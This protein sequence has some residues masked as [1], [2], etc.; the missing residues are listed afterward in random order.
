MKGSSTPRLPNWARDWIIWAR[1]IVG[2]WLA[3]KAMKKVPNPTPRTIARTDHPRLNP[4][5]G[6]VNPTT[7]VVRTKLPA[8]QKGPWCQTSPWR[9]DRGTTSIDLDSMTESVV[10]EDSCDDIVVSW[11][12]RFSA[13]WVFAVIRFGWSPRVVARS[14]VEVGAPISEDIAEVGQSLV[15]ALAQFDVGRDGLL[16][17]PVE[18][19][20]SDR[21]SVRIDDPG[22]RR[23]ISAPFDTRAIPGGE[24]HAG[25]R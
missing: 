25:Q 20:Q 19:G 12:Q 22:C 2:P 6:P 4:I 24:G 16:R 15:P 1:P 17:A 21:P 14:G 13:Q 18:I 11:F 9:S 5:V 23:P 3:W 7:R 10:F 8:N